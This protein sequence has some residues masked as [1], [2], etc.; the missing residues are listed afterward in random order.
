MQ[1]NLFE[2]E[3]FGHER[4]A[5]TGADKKKEG[6]IEVAENGTVFLDEIGEITPSI[7]AKLLRVL[8]TG[9]FRRLGGTRDLTS[10]VRFVA[11]TNRS[12]KEM[13][14]NG[15]FRSDLYYRLSAFCIDVPPLRD[16]R[17]DIKPIAQYFLE[18]RKFLRNVKK[19]FSPKTLKALTGYSWPGNIRELRN[20]IERAILVSGKSSRINTE[21]ISLQ[22]SSRGGSS[23]VDF[24]FDHEP[25]LEEFR[26]YYL[27]YLLKSHSGNRHE[28]ARALGMSER[29]TYRLIKKLGL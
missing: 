13:S 23:A 25:T 8:E 2:S 6:L 15:E 21:H 1:E 20:V 7:Q 4:G 5:F 14:D 18:T 11:A 16:R 10:N 24:S 3:L 29:N 17:D 28:V 26:N 12:L 9:K 27:E 19:E 22:D